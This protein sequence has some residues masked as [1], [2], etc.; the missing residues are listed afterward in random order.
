[1]SLRSPPRVSSQA[2][3]PAPPNLQI[4]TSAPRLATHRPQDSLH[5]GPKTRS[6]SG[7]HIASVHIGLLALASEW[8]KTYR[9]FTGLLLTIR[10]SFDCACVQQPTHIG[11]IIVFFIIV[12]MD[13]D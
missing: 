6:T 8:S 1:M 3:A 12:E 11:T 2:Q 10:L 7:R 9:A 4:S 13:I 5:I